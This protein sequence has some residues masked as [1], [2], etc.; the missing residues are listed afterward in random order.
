M[1]GE[2]I[3]AGFNLAIVIRDRNSPGLRAVSKGV[4]GWTGVRLGAYWRLATV[5]ECKR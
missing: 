3:P 2:L 1:V 5:E 4:Q